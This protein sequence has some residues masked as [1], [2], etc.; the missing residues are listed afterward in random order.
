MD[1]LTLVYQGLFFILFGASLIAYWRRR[2]PLTLDV[3]FLFGSL[4]GLFATQVIGDALPEVAEVLG[5]VGVMLLLAEPALAVRVTRH[6]RQLPPW[7]G[8]GLVAGYVASVGAFLWLGTAS[9]IA[10]I[11]IVA[12]FTIGNAAAAVI[13]ALEAG[14]RARFAR[15]RLVAAAISLGLLALAILIAVVGGPTASAAARALVVVVGLGFLLAF[16]PPR[17]LRRVGQQ[18]VAYRFLAD[19]GAVGPGA[20][21]ARLWQHLADAGRDL[22]GALASEVRLT[23]ARGSSGVAA[24]GDPEPGEP[25]RMVHFSREGQGGEIRLWTRGYALFED[26]DVTLLEALG[27][28]T[29]GAA[30]REDLLRERT[31][32]AERLAGT[33]VELARASAAKSDFLAAMS[34]EL[35]TP[36]NAIIGFSELLMAPP[37]GTPVAPSEVHEYA[38]HV[39]G[40]GLH[41]LELINDILDLSR[42]EAGRLELRYERV[43]VAR[44]LA[45]TLATVRPLA[46]ARNLTLESA[47]AQPL[48]ADVDAARLRQVVYNLVSNAIKF[49]P[50]GGTVSVS[51]SQDE[52]SLRLTVTDTG[53]GIDPA[54]QGRVF[55][56]FEQLTP[57]SAEGTGLGLALTRQ[58]VDAHGG[59]IKLE[60]ALGMGSSFT[61]VLPLRRPIVAEARAV[62]PDAVAPDDEAAPLVLVIEDDVAA[63]ELLRLQLRQ[64]GY[65]AAMAV[66]GESGLE[67]ARDLGPGAILLDI[68]L[69]GIDGWEILKR[70]RADPETSAIPV[71]VI[72]IVDDAAMGLALGAVDYFVKPVAREDLLAALGR[73]SLTSKVHQR[74]VTVLAIDDDPAALA[75]YRGALVPEGFRVVEAATGEDGLVA[76]RSEPIDLIV[77]DIMLPDL[78]GFEVAA[79]LKAD[80]I[81]AGI[82]IVVVTGRELDDADKERLNQHV[83]AVLTKGEAALAGLREWLARVSGEQAA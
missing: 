48:E 18:A 42:V 14:R 10:L 2:A 8:P 53:A 45:E 62:A 63:A 41:L 78:D 26:D 68:L 35:R 21:A 59:S 20:G 67:A 55:E 23:H 80:P 44:L 9:T 3:A 76:A 65:R 16:V 30:A 31:A 39:H 81:T 77:L 50:A 19:L 37:G 38:G 72:T 61:V 73:L 1:P 36:L 64:A 17:W 27:A 13:L 56:A 49:T 57:G 43:D 4:A 66:D 28:Q 25:A 83:L 54:D 34:H 51:L 74:V 69:P 46:E 22:T 12:Y 33:N 40:A 32:L 82:P 52:D 29:L 58:L 70:L 47:D 79:R 11:L 60:S 15:W 24:S 6:L 75:L 5:M 7:V 71:M